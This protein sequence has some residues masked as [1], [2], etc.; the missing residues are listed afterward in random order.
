M[1][2]ID[3]G[4]LT[5]IVGVITLV[6]G[7]LE[8]KYGLLNKITTLLG[9]I[10]ASIGVLEKLPLGAEANAVLQE[11]KEFIAVTD[12]ALIDKKLSVRELLDIAKE[13]KDIYLVLDDVMYSD[14]GTA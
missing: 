7:Y 8:T 14:G 10:R 2:E 12:E 13:L 1:V 3:T 6:V 4:I 5:A 9:L 11:A